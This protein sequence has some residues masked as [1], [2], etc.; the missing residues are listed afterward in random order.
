[1][2]D[3]LVESLFYPEKTGRF[4]N[5]YYNN[6][7][8]VAAFWTAIL[9]KEAVGSFD[10]PYLKDDVSRI[11]FLVDGSDT[12]L[13]EA[14]DFRTLI[15]LAPHMYDV[16]DGLDYCSD[17]LINAIDATVT[18]S[19]VWRVL[20]GERDVAS[21]TKCEYIDTFMTQRDSL[22]RSSLQR[23]KDTVDMINSIFESLE[24]Y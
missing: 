13:H 19:G 24:G 8:I 21:R 20:I 5:F 23:F 2:S 15:E 9:R 11:G 3:Q 12:H 16:L 1:M 4:N 17:A 7:T 18:G 6:A 14:K 10:E 22:E